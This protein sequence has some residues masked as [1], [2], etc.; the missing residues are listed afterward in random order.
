V[1]RIIW[2]LAVS[3]SLAAC[4]TYQAYDGPGQPSSATAVIH[5]DAK[6]RAE[7][8][9]AL[10]IRSVDGREVDLRYASVAVTAGHHVLIVDCQVGGATGGET[11]RHHVEVDAQGGEKYRLQAEMRPGNAS[12]ERVFLERS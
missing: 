3:M 8:P 6:L 2:L 9:L 11:S 7:L 5:G 10:V 1:T 12:C 4:A